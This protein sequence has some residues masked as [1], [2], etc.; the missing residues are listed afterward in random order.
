VNKKK[1]DFDKKTIKKK[2]TKVQVLIVAEQT[3][4][5]L[6]SGRAASQIQI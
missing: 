6:V 2:K 4:L 5:N 3:S 1:K